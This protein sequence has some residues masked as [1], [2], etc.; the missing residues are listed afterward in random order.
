LVAALYVVATPIGNLRDLTLRALDVL[1]AVDVL[2]AEDTRVTR[3]LLQHYGIDTRPISLHEHIE[4]EAGSRIVELLRAGRSVALVSDAGTPAVSDPGARLVRRVR[5]AGFA[6]VPVPGA[7]AVTAAV[8]AAGLPAGRF[9]FYGFLPAQTG[10]RVR[11]LEA[12]REQAAALVFYEAPHRVRETLADLAQVLGGERELV[13]ARELTKLF[14]TIHACR[15]DEAL[16]WLDADPNRSKGEFVL[17]VQGAPA[18]GDAQA[19]E[20]KRVLAVLLRELPLK[21]AVQLAAEITGAKRNALYERALEL[22]GD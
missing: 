17:L 5:Q 19:E 16:A 2:A 13:I 11:E 1:K 10:G 12:L 18:P 4:E 21:Q 7:S 9:L 20:G 6:I 14:E 15:L 8:S 22:K 3:H